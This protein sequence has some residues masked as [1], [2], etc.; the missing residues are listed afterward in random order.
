MPLAALL[1]VLIVAVAVFLASRLGPRWL[2]YLLA[3][4]AGWVLAQPFKGLTGLLAAVLLAPGK[5]PQQAVGAIQHAWWFP[6]LVAALPAVFEE[7]GKYLPLRW[8]RVHDRQQALALGIGAGAIEGLYLAVYAATGLLGGAGLLQLTV[9]L[10]ERTWAIALHAGLA[11][12]DGASAAQRRGRWLAVAMA[13]HFLTGLAPGWY[14]QARAAH[15][16]GAAILLAATE[17]LTPLIAMG[18]LWF[19]RGLWA[20]TSSATSRL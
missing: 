12:L 5:S 2:P 14:Q 11:T 17:A 18:V 4:A 1:T 15:A 13:A 9:G 20:S 6:L 7:L 16:P 8:M 10:W 3:G 19:G